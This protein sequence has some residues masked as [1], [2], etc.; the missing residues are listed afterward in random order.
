MKDSAKNL[1]LLLLLLPMITG[2]GVLYQVLLGVDSTPEWKS[3]REVK[4]QAKKYRIPAENN[5]VLDTAT[6]YQGL[7]ELYSNRAK[8]LNMSER[9]SSEIKKFNRVLKDDTQPVQFRLFDKSG[10][11]VF[12]IVNCY[13]DPPIPMNWNVSG[14]FDVFPP[15]T[16]IES[17]NSHNFDLQFLLS[18]ASTLDQNKLN[19]AALP[20]SDYYGVILWNEFFRRPSRKLIKTVRKYIED[21]EQSVHLIYIHN[22]NAY[23]W[24]VMDAE[25]KERVKIALQEYLDSIE[26]EQQ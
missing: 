18:H 7:S 15:K 21:Q 14:C 6:Y 22:Q 19:V 17:L 16:D 25:T 9:D 5:L 8:E 10:T 11:E 4:K 13:L 20:D 3:D 24:Q 2:C 26:Q 23:L 12:K 1:F